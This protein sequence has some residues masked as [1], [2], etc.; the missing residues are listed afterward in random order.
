[1]LKDRIVSLDERM[2]YIMDRYGEKPE[3][4]QN[5]YHAVDKISI[6]PRTA[7]LRA[8]RAM[9]CLVSNLVKRTITEEPD[10]VILHV[11]HRGGC[12]G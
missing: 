12:A 2:N 11:R 3:P 4:Q 1:M 8:K 9:A 5:V 6:V 7:Q 10:E